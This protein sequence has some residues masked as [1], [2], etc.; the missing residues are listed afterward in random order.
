MGGH[1]TVRGSRVP[2]MPG[3]PSPLQ[4]CSPTRRASVHRLL[5]LASRRHAASRPPRQNETRLPATWCLLQSL[6]DRRELRLNLHP[7]P[8]S[9]SPPLTPSPTRSPFFPLKLLQI[10]ANP[11]TSPPHPHT[12][13][14]THTKTSLPTRTSFLVI[15][16]CP[17]S[18]SHLHTFTRLHTSH[19]PC[20]AMFPQNPR[21]SISPTLRNV[22]TPSICAS[23]RMAS[24]NAPVQLLR[25]FRMLEFI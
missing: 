2:C 25:S 1:R 18:Q 7:I 16:W 5:L 21:A 23:R 24:V 19:L 6:P 10:P 4:P 20:M 17:P 22:V 12:H 13:T 9:G 15:T 3:Q 14:H 8:S 11:H